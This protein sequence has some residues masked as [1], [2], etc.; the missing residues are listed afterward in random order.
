MKITLHVDKR[1]LQHATIRTQS[2][3]RFAMALALTRTVQATQTYLRSHLA[4]DFTIRSSWVAKGIRIVPAT[5]ATLTAAVG[6]KD[7]FMRLQTIG[8]QKTPRNSRAV[9]IPIGARPTLQSTTRPG[10]W[11]SRLLSKV[12]GARRYGPVRKGQ[13]QRSLARS[14]YFVAKQG[15]LAP[16]HEILY[17]RKGRRVVAIWRFAAAV[18]IKPR[19]HLLAALEKTAK[20]E[21]ERQLAAAFKRA[22][23]KRH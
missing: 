10:K 16:D 13:R 11:P 20:L 23:Q 8:G 15:H 2:N 5:K 18:L 17:Q 3:L 9:A 4:S 19:W 12:V 21:F 7:A 1:L 22:D 6:S 14:G